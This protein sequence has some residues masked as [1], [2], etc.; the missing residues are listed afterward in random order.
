MEE[1]IREVL[2]NSSGAPFLFVGSG[3]SRRYLGLEDW[4]GLLSRFCEGIK[5]FEYYLATADGD[6]PKAA[7][8]MAQDFHHHWWEDEKF[9][10]SRQVNKAFATGVSSAL[11]I[12][13][14]N[15]IRDINFSERLDK[16]LEEE[17]SVLKSLN[18]DGVITT[19]WDLFL[20]DIFPE[21]KVYVGQEQLLFSNPQ[22][23]AEIYKIHGSVE[24]PH[25]LVLTEEDYRE[26]YRKN[27]Y[28]VAKLITIFI[29]HPIIF[30]GY[31]VSDPHISALIF[32][33]A[34]CLAE[35]KLDSFSKN[36]IFLKRS[37]GTGDAVE[38]VNFAREG[39]SVAAT[40]VKTDDFSKLYRVVAENRRK[41]PARILRY[42]KEQMFELVRSSDPQTKMAVIDIDDLENKNDIEFVVGVGVAENRYAKAEKVAAEFADSGY[43]GLERKDL[44]RDLLEDNSAYEGEKVLLNVYPRLRRFG[45][46]H[47]I[48]RYLR[49]AGI[50]SVEALDA[51]CFE[52]A[53]VAF[54]RLRGKSLAYN[55]YKGSFELNHKSKTAQQIV[56]ELGAEKATMY[57]AFLPPEQMPNDWLREFLKSNFDHEFRD[58]YGFTF[59]KLMCLYDLRVYGF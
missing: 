55:S 9:A 23:I 48:F 46:F 52:D 25:T 30:I 47:P 27:P 22:S 39:R 37:S 8:L 26:F 20:E 50:D 33:I 36:L 57:L 24:D 17:F 4:G 58:P 16:D 38:T 13:I 18:V 6:L 12:E 10:N 35:E 14:S 32:E 51:S 40:V 53:K 15:Y 28:L 43:S 42:C 7:S 3:F 19:N 54:A 21:Y 44:F 45:I 29:E 5:D 2:A 34:S 31:S 49:S 59:N 1:K 56:D 11:K 41:I